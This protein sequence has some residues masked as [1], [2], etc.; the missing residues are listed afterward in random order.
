MDLKTLKL[1]S[2]QLDARRLEAF[3]TYEKTL[4]HELDRSDLPDWSGR[5]AFAHGKALTASGLDLVELGKLKSLVGDFSG[6]RSNVAQIKARLAAGPAQGKPASSLDRAR[7]ELPRLEDLSGFQ[8]RYGADAVGLLLAREAELVELHRE[9]A[10]REGQG[11]LH[12][13]S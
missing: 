6:R 7:A 5:Y 8:E 3:I 4:L 1:A 2:L 10:R 12:P 11:H 9:L 13:R